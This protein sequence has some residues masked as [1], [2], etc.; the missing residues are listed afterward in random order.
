MRGVEPNRPV[1]T[2]RVSGEDVPASLCWSGLL[3]MAGW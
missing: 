1:A 3:G 2:M